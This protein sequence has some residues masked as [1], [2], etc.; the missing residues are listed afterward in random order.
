MGKR[1]LALAAALLMSCHLAD[2]LDPPK[3]PEGSQPKNDQ[4]V[5]DVISAEIITITAATGGSTCTGAT[6]DRA[7]TLSPATVT[8][9]LGKEFQFKNTD[10]VAYDVKG[11]DGVVWVSV[12]AGRSSAFTTIKKTGTWSY[13]LGACK[14]GGTVVIEP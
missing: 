4:C 7:P 8:L 6:S 3:C 10:T 1:I 5:Q 11:N 9:K 14:S 13:T 12:P 2:D